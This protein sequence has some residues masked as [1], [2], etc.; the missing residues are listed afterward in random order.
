M[1]SSGRENVKLW[2]R[3]A[4]E[5]IQQDKQDYNKRR[6]W[7]TA[8]KLINRRS[9]YIAVYKEKLAVI[10]AGKKVPTDYPTTTPSSSLSL[11]LPH[12]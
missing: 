1:L 3:F 5:C 10:G 9:K 7:L 6:S 4:Y 12:H 2:W 11:L 8:C